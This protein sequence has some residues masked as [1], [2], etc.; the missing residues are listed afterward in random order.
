MKLI[1]GLGNPGPDYE[2]H[3]HNIGQW[4]LDVLTKELKLKWEK[5][6]LAVVSWT[7]IEKEDCW[8]A[9]PKTFMNESGKA[10]KVLLNEKNLS[11]KDLIVIHDDMDIALGKLR[12][13]FASGF[14][15]HNG[16]KSIIDTLG[17]KDFYRVRLGVGRPPAHRDPAEY[18]LQPFKRAE[19]EL[20][21][22]LAERAAH[23]IKDFMKHPL[24]WVQNHYHES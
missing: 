23:S 8:F 19:L 1:V 18:V 5:N 4:V 11:P 6:S 17:T 14:G 24:D 3:K 20:A 2:N 9:K 16:A 22:S 7:T 10:V 12:W 21:E 15:G 13:G